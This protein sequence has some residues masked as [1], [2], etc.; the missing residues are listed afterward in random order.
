MVTV[1][2]AISNQ[3]AGR[4]MKRADIHKIAGARQPAGVAHMKR[5][6]MIPIIVHLPAGP[7]RK[8]GVDMNMGAGVPPATLN[9]AAVTSINPSQG[10]GMKVGMIDPVAHQLLVIINIIS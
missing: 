5:M 4:P 10:V 3:G 8:A 2:A 1:G 7:M 6:G 9:P